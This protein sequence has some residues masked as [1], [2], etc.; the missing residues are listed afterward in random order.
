MLRRPK[1]L[2]VSEDTPDL[3]SHLPRYASGRAV[4][5]A[6]REAI[7]R[8]SRLSDYQLVIANN[9]DLEAA[10]PALKEQLE[11]YEKQG[12]GL[13]VIAGEHSNYQ[14]G[15]TKEDALDRA[16]PATLAPPRSPEGTAVILIIDKSSSMEGAQDRIGA[17]GRLRRGGK[18][19]PRGPGGRADV[20]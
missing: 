16:L 13:L 15:K 1:V 20:R 19:A 4:R 3:D 11:Q 9:W 8:G 17:A 10:S 18:S 7:S 12:G 6:T 2:Y 5:R 14:E